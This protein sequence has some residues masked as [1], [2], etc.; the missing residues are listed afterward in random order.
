MMQSLSS[1]QENTYAELEYLKNRVKYLEEFIQSSYSNPKTPPPG[2][3]YHHHPPSNYPYMPPHYQSYGQPPVHYPVQ[4]S[5]YAPPNYPQQGPQSQQGQGRRPETNRPENGGQNYYSSRGG[6]A[7][8]RH[9]PSASHGQGQGLQGTQGR[10]ASKPGS[11]D[12]GAVSYGGQNVYPGQ[13]MEQEYSSTTRGN[14]YCGKGV[15]NLNKERTR[16]D[17]KWEGKETS[18]S[19]TT[20]DEKIKNSPQTRGRRSAKKQA[21]WNRI[22]DSLR[23]IYLL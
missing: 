18:H 1:F 3:P 2:Y 4:Y 6:E 10:S 22:Q 19:L 9:A 16:P 7:D 11:K 20:R 13:R 8:Q 23:V 14:F 5:N 17:S 21:L 15:F 12:R